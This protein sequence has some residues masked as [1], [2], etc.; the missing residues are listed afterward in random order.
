[1]PT[2]DAPALDVEAF[3]EQCLGVQFDQCASLPADV[4]G[5][6]DFRI[7]AP[8]LVMVN[9]DLTGAALDDEDSPL[10]LKG[11]WRATVA[12]EACHVLFHRCL[13]NLSSQQGSLFG[14]EGDSHEPAQRVQRCLKRDM[15]YGRM[16]SD[17][18]EVQANMG[19]AALLM[20]ADWN[21]LL[22]EFSSKAIREH[23]ALVEF[24]AAS[25]DLFAADADD[26]AVAI[27]RS[28]L[29]PAFS[30]VVYRCDS[31]PPEKVSRSAKRPGKCT[32]CVAAR[33]IADALVTK[34]EPQVTWSRSKQL[35]DRQWDLFVLHHDPARKLLYLHSSDTSS[36]HEELAHAVGGKKIQPWST[37]SS[38]EVPEPGPG[39][40]TL[41]KCVHKRFDHPNGSG[42]SVNSAAT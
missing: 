28:L 27:A 5:Q 26:D 22:S 36:L 37:A 10:G 30:A 42:D 14:E 8:P 17:W 23:E 25:K 15:V 33:A 34:S 24:L 3:V 35:R 41:W 16:G 19:M 39:S 12:H 40:K 11:R 29:R 38:P 2:V 7:G 21:Y 4:L 20:D 9:A 13:F 32:R 31:F 6:T 18:R 1:M